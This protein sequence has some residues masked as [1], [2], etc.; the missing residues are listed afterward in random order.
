MDPK[1][2]LFLEEMSKQFCTEIAGVKLEITDIKGG[3]ATYDKCLNEVSV[4]QQQH[5][6]WVAALQEVV[7][8]F[9]TWKPKVELSLS[10]VK[11]E[12]TKLN[13]F[14]DRDVKAVPNTK[15]GILTIGS[16]SA[17]PSSRADTNGPHGHRVDIF[18]RD[19]GFGQVFTHIHDPIKGTITDPLP[20]QFHTE[21][22]PSART[23]IR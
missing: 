4:V 22:N 21:P 1:V 5:D 6:V 8:S 10:S 9:N 23:P 16:A 20:P 13:T 15:A 17:P 19:C 11:L 2:K 3:L 7:E 18:H 14:F 12:L